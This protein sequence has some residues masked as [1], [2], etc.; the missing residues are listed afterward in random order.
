MYPK[1][2]DDIKQLKVSFVKSE[3]DWPCAVGLEDI[4][5]VADL[6]DFHLVFPY[7]AWMRKACRDAMSAKIGQKLFVKC[8]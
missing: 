6:S 5:N 4:K 7:D 8:I 3:W 2:L 1:S